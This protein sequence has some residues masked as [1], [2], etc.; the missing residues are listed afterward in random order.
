[1]RGGAEEALVA[2][3]HQVVGSSPTPAKG[4]QYLRDFTFLPNRIVTIVVSD[5]F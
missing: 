4:D 1:M 2:H 5:P 3:N